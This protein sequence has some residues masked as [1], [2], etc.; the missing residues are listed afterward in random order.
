VL[1]KKFSAGYDAG[2]TFSREAKPALVGAWPALW[3]A[4]P[5]FRRAVACALDVASTT[6]ID[7]TST[8]IPQESSS[9]SS[10]SETDAADDTRTRVS[11]RR[12]A[13][14]PLASTTSPVTPPPPPTL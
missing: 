12:P 1:A 2:T 14:P 6:K 10:S 8:E 5:K 11:R 4:S 3:L 9:S 7:A 13:A